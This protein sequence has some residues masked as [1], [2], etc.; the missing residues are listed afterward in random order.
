[1]KKSNLKSAFV[2]RLTSKSFIAN[3]EFYIH[4]AESHLMQIYRSL[5]EDYNLSDEHVYFFTELKVLLELAKKQHK[6]EIS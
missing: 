3:T 5:A 2:P 6:E 1:M 4:L